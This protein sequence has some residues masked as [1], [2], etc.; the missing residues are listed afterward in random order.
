MFLIIFIDNS[1][2]SKKKMYIVLGLDF[3]FVN[4]EKIIHIKLQFLHL[5]K[6]TLFFF[7]KNLMI[8]LILLFLICAKLSHMLLL[9][10]SILQQW[11]KN[12]PSSL[13]IPYFLSHFQPQVPYRLVPYKKKRV[14][15]L[16]YT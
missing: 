9:F 14:W 8:E 12:L 3:E 13:A 4:K 10:L 16:Q 7:I 5:F 11:M 6:Y 2:Y 15:C 1:S